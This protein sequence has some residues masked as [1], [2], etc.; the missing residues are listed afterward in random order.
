MARRALPFSEH[1][2]VL[3]E[4]GETA[5]ATG[6]SEATELIELALPNFS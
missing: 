1:S 4:P 6:V 2:A 3:L 5:I